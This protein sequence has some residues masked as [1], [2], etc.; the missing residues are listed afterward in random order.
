MA[1][2]LKP[3]SI[4]GQEVRARCHLARGEH[5]SARAA[6]LHLQILGHS[7]KEVL[8]GVTIDT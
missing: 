5:H 3:A 6:F 7:H 4:L 2:L 8:F 1:V